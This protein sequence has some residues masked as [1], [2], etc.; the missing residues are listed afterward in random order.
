[1]VFGLT[2]GKK[3]APTAVVEVSTEPRDEPV[4]ILYASQRGNGEGHAEKLAAQIT[5]Q[6]SVEKIQRLT[7]TQA[8]ITIVPQCMSVD[9]FLTDHKCQWTRLV[10]LVVSSYGIGGAPMNGRKFR[11]LCDGWVQDAKKEQQ[12]SNP[13]LHFLDGLQFALLGLGDSYYK[14]YMENPTVTHDALVS[15]GATLLVGKGTAKDDTNHPFCA[16]DATDGPEEQHKVMDQWTEEL[17]PLVANVV[18]QE[19]LDESK[20][21]EMQAMTE[22]SM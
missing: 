4:L 19:P 2:F 6:C 18:I 10:I 9:D 13:A 5:D 20:L 8:Q 15:K 22:Q 21:K 11:T 17:W 14:T 7:K 16:A 12:G 3:K 1:M